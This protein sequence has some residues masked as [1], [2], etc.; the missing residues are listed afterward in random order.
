M[1]LRL[2]SGCN[3][4]SPAWHAAAT[5]AGHNSR[6]MAA[7]SV[8]M[9]GLRW[10]KCRA[11]LKRRLHFNS[12]PLS[13]PALSHFLAG[14]HICDYS[15]AQPFKMPAYLV[16]LSNREE[17]PDRH[18][19][20]G[21]LRPEPPMLRCPLQSFSGKLDGGHFMGLKE[22]WCHIHDMSDPAQVDDTERNNEINAEAA[23]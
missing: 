1:N 23:R 20:K 7:T 4:L 11:S 18:P 6:Q 5:R 2:A 13:A 10:R 3:G 14:R 16:H 19:G 12:S 17:H 8:L 9:G 22:G 21:V 15:R